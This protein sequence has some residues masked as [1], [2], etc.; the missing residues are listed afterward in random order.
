MVLIY[1]FGVW[2]GGALL[3]QGSDTGSGL[4]GTQ[5]NP[6]TNPSQQGQGQNGNT[7]PQTPDTM[8]TPGNLPVQAGNYVTSVYQA[9]IPSIVTITAVTPQGGKTDP[10]EDVGTGFFID[11]HGDI[12]TNNHVLNGQS[13]VTVEFNHQTYTGEV[14]G[15][16][17]LDDLAV[18]HIAVDKPTPY[19]EFGTA[20]TLVPGQPVIAIGNPFQLEDS[21]SVGIVSG[22]NR[23]MSSPSG[24]MMNGLVQ[25]D[26]ALNPGNSGGPLLDASGRV[27]GINTAIESPVEGSVGI[28]FAIPIDRLKEVLP[29]LLTGSRI[30]HPWLGISAWDIDPLVKQEL[31]LPVQSGVLVITVANGGPAKAA[32]IH[33][34]SGSADNPKGDGDIIIAVNGSPVTS[35]ADLTGAISEY[36]VG[37]VIH[38]T[39]LRHGQKLDIPVKLAAW[40]NQQP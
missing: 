2:T 27:I 15:T 12:A 30:E 31:N 7:A 4:F 11:S 24:H 34:D 21:V 23:S 35:V 32:G 13:K 36:P 9:A 22:L 10:Q 17:P 19:L 37:T 26:A 18:V 40:P 20:K 38:L 39:I 14:L 1:G 28:G 29:K 5:G 8:T 16:D 25:T 3:H 33:P 6:Y